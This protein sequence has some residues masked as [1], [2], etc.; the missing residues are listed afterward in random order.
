MH[1][2]FFLERVLRAVTVAAIAAKENGE[3]RLRDS[4]FVVAKGAQ[5]MSTVIICEGGL[6]EPSPL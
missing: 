6:V 2:G 3:P 4:P 5:G 1:R